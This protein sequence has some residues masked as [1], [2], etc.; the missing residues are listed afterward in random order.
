MRRLPLLLAAV[1]VALVAG[2]AALPGTVRAN[3]C[4]TPWEGSGTAGDPYRVATA[5]DL[6]AVRFC[7]Y[8]TD[9]HWLQTANIDLSG[10]SPWA[11]IGQVGLEFKGTYDGG[12]HTI[13][14]LL[15]ND[16]PSSAQNQPKGLF[17]A[18][19]GAVISRLTIDGA[20]IEGVVSAHGIL[21][22]Y[23][24]GGS[25]TDVTI[26]NGTIVE[27]DDGEANYGGLA[28]Y[29]RATEISRVVVDG[30][31][32]V[33]GP[34]VTVPPNFAGGIVGQA[35]EGTRISDSTVTRG[36]I[37]GNG[38]V[39]GIAGRLQCVRLER[40]TVGS[41][42]AVIGADGLVGGA[43]GS[44]DGL[45]PTDASADPAMVDV[46][47]AGTVTG[48]EGVGGL[49]GRG[50]S[51]T[52]TRSAATGAVTATTGDAG[53]LIGRVADGALTDVYALG[54][55]TAAGPA[56]GLVG[57]VSDNST[58]LLSVTRAY[59]AGR[60][61]AGAGQEAG[62]LFSGAS[63]ACIVSV[64]VSACAVE[65]SEVAVTA[66]FWD[67]EGTGQ[68]ASSG[69]GVA[70][71]TA[72]LRDVATFSA[73]GWSIA[74][75]RVDAATATW[76]ICTGANA[77]R[78][79]LQWQ[80]AAVTGPCATPPSQPRNVRV[81]AGNGRLTISW[82]EPAS[83]GGSAITDYTATAAMQNA[84]AKAIPKCTTT[85]PTTT[86]TISGLRNGRAYRV[87]VTAANAVGTGTAA[88]AASTA[89]PRRALTVL[90]TRRSGR[91]VVTRV[92]VTGAGT[93]TQVGRRVGARGVACRASRAQMKRAGVVTL[94]C[95]LDAA[96]MRTLEN[97][98]LRLRVV[99]RFAPATGAALTATR[100]VV[101]P[102][103]P[104]AAAVTG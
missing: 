20:R 88:V 45:C 93:L 63:I 69:G 18:T 85:A 30:I 101:F 13:T 77:G 38:H 36:T 104:G 33:L 84:N 66:S 79:F 32:I 97:G 31:D 3:G 43:V 89:T 61:T 82:D 53:G 24:T 40:S 65:S 10:Y 9:Y 86:C 81:L 102:R 49:L 59:A 12:G 21:S 42:V 73:A 37:R 67:Q 5:A 8:H 17:Q 25:V 46:S 19:S 83:N 68:A 26:R 98:A 39:G 74:P 44:F 78:P 22:G 15:V 11:P 51:A 100:L 7:A 48:T 60:V 35:W 6:D 64:G 29:A 27:N 94:R 55:V 47:A 75:A 4:P 1:I 56:G 71:S 72:Q 54:A 58:D 80:P 14:G 70:R 2:Q 99:T 103:T 52:V 91:A 95:A 28:G 50:Y 34:S 16:D 57:A 92:R 76:G 87:S 90:S 96:A 41:G 23:V 62:G